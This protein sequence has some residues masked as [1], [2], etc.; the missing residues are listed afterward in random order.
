MKRIFSIEEG[1]LLVFVISPDGIMIN[2]DKIESI[3]NIL[4]LH[5]KREV[6]SFLGKIK[7]VHRF[8]SNFS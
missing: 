3:N 6:Q 8:I 7:F 1:T 5:N 4:I 2:L